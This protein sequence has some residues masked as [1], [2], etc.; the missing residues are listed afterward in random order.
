MQ[1]LRKPACMREPPQIHTPRQIG[2]KHNVIPV[3]RPGSKPAGSQ[4][5]YTLDRNRLGIW[6]VARDKA[7]RIGQFPLGDSSQYR[8][9]RPVRV[10]R[11]L[12]CE[13]RRAEKAQ[14][15]DGRDE[16]PKKKLR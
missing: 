3:R 14:G 9:A 5:E 4:R 11:G 15:R 6:V 16:M 1:L 12:L 8:N 2:R 7:A 10:K 13:K